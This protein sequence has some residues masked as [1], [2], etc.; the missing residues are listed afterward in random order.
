MFTK[1]PQARLRLDGLE[2]RLMKVERTMHALEMDWADTLDKVKRMM[3]RIAKRAEVAEKAELADASAAPG[4]G[5][6][7]LVDRRAE[8]NAQILARRQKGR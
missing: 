5:E 1:D 7:A 2:E 4:E 6:L 3:Q 8:I